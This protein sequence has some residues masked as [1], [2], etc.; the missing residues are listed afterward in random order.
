M[1]INKIRFGLGILLTFC[2]SVS[3]E[4]VLDQQNPNALST[5]LFWQDAEDVQQAVVGAYSPMS[6]ILV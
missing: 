4:D 3:C 2:Y 1:R 5:D 6:T